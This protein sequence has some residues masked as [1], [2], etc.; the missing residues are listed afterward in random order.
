MRERG[1]QLAH[2]RGRRR[3]WVGNHIRTCR[4]SGGQVG[5]SIRVES[6]DPHYCDAAC[7]APPPQEGREPMTRF[8]AAG[9]WREVLEID[10]Q[11]IGATALHCIVNTSVRTG[12]E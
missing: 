10:D 8:V 2:L 5:W 1:V 9:R 7:I 3:H 6:V 12:A 4:H 11:G